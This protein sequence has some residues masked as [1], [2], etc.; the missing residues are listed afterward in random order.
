MVSTLH[1][2]NPRTLLLDLAL[3]NER[4]GE[5]LTDKLSIADWDFV[6]FTA[7]REYLGDQG[8]MESNYEEE[9]Y[10][11]DPNRKTLRVERVDLKDHY[12][13]LG[14]MMIPPA[15]REFLLVPQSWLYVP[16]PEAEL[17]IASRLALTR[18]Q[19]RQAERV[20]RLSHNFAKLKRLLTLK[21]LPLSEERFQHL[22][23]AILGY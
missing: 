18:E 1:G 14:D 20:I 5:S 9:I 21:Q 12:V 3:T 17:F 22:C 8:P 6:D 15:F 4:L 13:Q 19:R 7:S 16:D 11:P 2:A 10:L 23:R